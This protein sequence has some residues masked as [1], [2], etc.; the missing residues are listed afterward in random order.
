MS[1]LTYVYTHSYTYFY[2]TNYICVNTESEFIPLSPMDSSIS[3]TTSI[4]LVSFH[5][6]SII[7]HYQSDKPGS[8][9]PPS[10]NLAVQFHYT[11]IVILELLI[12]ISM[13]NPIVTSSV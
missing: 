10:I 7:S 2:I 11:C 1:I 4:I 13:G 9:H 12:H 8:H 6:L 3:I 5:C